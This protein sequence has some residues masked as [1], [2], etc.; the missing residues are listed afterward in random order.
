MSLLAAWIPIALSV[1][2]LT[3]GLADP[4]F[5]AQWIE[6]ETG[7]VEIAQLF[8]LSAAIV[9]IALILRDPLARAQPG[10]SLWL[11]LVALGC[12]YLVGEE[13][14]WGQ[15]Y[16]GWR[17]PD[18]I[19]VVN[20]Q[21]E[22]NLHN[23]STWLNEKPRALFEAAVIVGGIVHP[24]LVAW[25]GRGPLSRPWWLGPRLACLPS[26]VLAELWRI[27]ERLFK[28]EGLRSTSVAT[29]VLGFVR[30]SEVQELYFFYFIL[31]YV[32]SIRRRLRTRPT[33]GD[34]G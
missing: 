32:L 18:W 11:V 30:Y 20:R 23:T 28:I 9:L 2:L 5:Y 34:A 25:R 27:P 14:S 1:I 7:F 16:F 21:H 31:I 13:A 24:V 4:A 33:P 10:L 29:D 15:H 17:T 22:I 8:P 12:V 26:A 19:A 3:L 6:G